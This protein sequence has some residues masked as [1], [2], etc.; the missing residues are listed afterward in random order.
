MNELTACRE[1]VTA[2]RNLL[3]L[4]MLMLQ[5]M[6]LM[7][8]VARLLVMMT[9]QWPRVVDRLRDTKRGQV[10][11]AAVSD[12]TSLLL[13]P[14]DATRSSIALARRETARRSVSVGIFCNC[15]T[16][17]D[18][19]GRLEAGT[20]TVIIITSSLHDKTS[21]DKPVKIWPADYMLV[22]HTHH[23]KTRYNA[24]TLFKQALTFLRR[25]R[26]RNSKY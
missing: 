15:C 9:V 16:V 7:L 19:C 13:Q 18:E 20:Q 10:W 6:L 25:Y 11:R 21:H 1:D 12:V 24:R 26:T 8:V 17:Q 14:H 5:L 4:L 22:L 2:V 23:S 3:L